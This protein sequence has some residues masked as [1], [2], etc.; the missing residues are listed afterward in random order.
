M[1]TTITPLHSPNCSPLAGPDDYDCSPDCP[2]AQAQAVADFHAARES[3]REAER[4]LRAAALHYRDV[5]R[6]MR[7]NAS[8]ERALA[9]SLGLS[10][11]A[12]RD[13]LRPDRRENR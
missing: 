2:E 13:L 8:S 3:L 5:V 6:K 12:V 1:E 11:T 7:G 4:A 10:Q 9:R